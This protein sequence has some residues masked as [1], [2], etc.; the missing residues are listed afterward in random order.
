MATFL[1]LPHIFRNNYRNLVG[2]LNVIVRLIIVCAIVG[3]FLGISAKFGHKN[4]RLP[5]GMVKSV[6]INKINANTHVIEASK[7][8]R[9]LHQNYNSQNL[10]LAREELQT[11]LGLDSKNVFALN[12][13]ENINVIDAA[14]IEQEIHKVQEILNRR[15]DYALAWTKLAILYQRLGENDLAIKAMERANSLNSNL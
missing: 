9:S 4:S 15:P 10:E 6:S 11:A 3:S 5:S 13:L 8:I 14:L 12:E 7:Y 1:K 2:N